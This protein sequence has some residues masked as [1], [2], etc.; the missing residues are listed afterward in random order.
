MDET[1]VQKFITI[2]CPGGDIESI[3]VDCRMA[4][5]IEMLNDNGF[6]TEYCCSGHEEEAFLGMYIKFYNLVKDKEDDLRAIVK[7]IPELYIEDCYEIFTDIGISANY[8]QLTNPTDEELIMGMKLVFK[9]HYTN[10]EVVYNGVV[11]FLIIRTTM[12]KEFI[13]KHMELKDCDVK[14]NKKEVLDTIHSFET[15]L[16][17]YNAYGTV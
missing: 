12:Q 6:Y 14:K 15:V 11:H 17:I 2:K 4:K 13:D 16:S 1:Q 10:E 9:E 7:R 5:L 3:N 8:V